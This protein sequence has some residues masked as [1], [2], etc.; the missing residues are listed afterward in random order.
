MYSSSKNV[1]SCKNEI[2]VYLTKKCSNTSLVSTIGSNIPRL[3][4]IRKHKFLFYLMLKLFCSGPG[5]VVGIATAYGLDG[6]GIESRW[7][8]E[9]FCTCPDRL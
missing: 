6:P 1:S 3:H 2:S 7:G 4:V 8:G 9:I 5:S